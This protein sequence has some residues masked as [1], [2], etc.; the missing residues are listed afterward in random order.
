MQI[1]TF[2]GNLGRDS[3]LRS[4]QSGDDVLSFSVAVKQGYGRDAKSEWL[5]C[6]L[7][8]KR[9]R[10]LNEF[11]LK[12]VKVV[13]NGDL[14]IGEY[15]GKPQYE[16]NVREVE[17]MSRADQNGAREDR[18]DSQKADDRSGSWEDDLS[19]EIPF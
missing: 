11:L 18:R 4:T 14:T 10:S 16:V 15:Q 6:S 8:G 5:R 12:G 3:E 17:M 9:A 2:S 1:I 7:W 19:D 13:V